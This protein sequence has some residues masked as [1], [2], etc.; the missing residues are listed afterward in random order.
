MVRDSE[1][2]RGQ[3]SGSGVQW[4]LFAV[5][6]VLFLGAVLVV[7]GAPGV[8]LDGPPGD[9]GGT[10]TAT[11]AAATPT[12]DG[13]PGGQTAGGS[14]ATA[15][16]TPSGSNAT[17]I[18]RVN[19]G[20]PRLSVDDGPDWSADLA[21]DPSKHLNAAESNTVTND[22]PD[23][24]TVESDVPSTTPKEMFRTYRFER[25][26]EKPQYEEMVWNFSVEPGRVYEVRVYDMEPYFTDGEGGR[27][28]EKSYQKHGPRSFGIAVENEVV[29]E[30]HEPFKAHGHD[31]GAVHTFR[32]TAEDGVLT[33][34]FLHETN[35]P[36]VSGI[37]IVAVGSENGTG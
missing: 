23:S 7:A 34:R 30:N 12:T 11:P 27:E 10:P 8:L 13:T 26:A 16:A 21:E 5:G 15:T 20:G 19:A 35:T 6:G 32:T 14:T 28:Y 37:E 9:G 4:L 22:T 31:V 17:V 2:P 3:I 1:P 36:T 29:L 24:I 33:V 25:G 18:Y